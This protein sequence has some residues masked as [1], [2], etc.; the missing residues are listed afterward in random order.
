[1]YHTSALT[2]GA[3]DIQKTYDIVTHRVQETDTYSKNYV[4]TV[5]PKQSE[6]EIFSVVLQV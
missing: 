6:Y 3:A 2:Q 5:R 4:P 1:M